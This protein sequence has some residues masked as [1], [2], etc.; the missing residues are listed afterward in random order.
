VNGEGRSKEWPFS[1]D[2]SSQFG[3][4]DMAASAEFIK[5]LAA[6]LWPTLGFVFLWLYKDEI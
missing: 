2:N 6:L 4:L 5:S 1:L 3:R